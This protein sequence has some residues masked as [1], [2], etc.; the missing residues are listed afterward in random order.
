MKKNKQC[1][2]NIINNYYGFSGGGGLCF[3][4]GLAPDYTNNKY[5]VNV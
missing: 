3:P 2:N 4:H 1:Q 5:I